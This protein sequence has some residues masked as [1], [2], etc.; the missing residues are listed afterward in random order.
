[1][2]GDNLYTVL[3]AAAGLLG[4]IYTAKAGPRSDAPAVTV[5][6]PEADKDGALEVSPE[7]WSHF[8][9]KINTLE[10]K[11]D[12]LTELVER[13]TVRV[14]ALERLL[15]QAMRIIRQANRRLI[16]R[17]EPAEEIP[18]ELVPYSID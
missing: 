2:N 5:A 11:V 4:A 13:Q 9:G 16:A 8:N 1:M 10:H 17:G 15:R 12:H 14:G 3:V 7:I 6:A 18:Q